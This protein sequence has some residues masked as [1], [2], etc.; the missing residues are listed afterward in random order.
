MCGPVFA[1]IVV[2]LVE[3][4]TFVVGGT[5]Q[6][7]WPLLIVGALT[8]AASAVWLVDAVRSLLRLI[9]LNRQP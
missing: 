3:G 1:F 8:A 2:G 9:R 5:Q 6:D 4:I 7:N